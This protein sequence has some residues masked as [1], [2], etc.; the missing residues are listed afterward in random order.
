MSARCRRT[1]SGATTSMRSAKPGQLPR[2]HELGLG[3]QLD[4][5][6]ARPVPP[7]PTSTRLPNM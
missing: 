3:A 6:P 5:D 7:R 1:L 4:L 2:H